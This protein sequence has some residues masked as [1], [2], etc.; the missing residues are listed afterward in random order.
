LLVR[1]AVVVAWDGRHPVW[2]RQALASID[3]QLPAAAQKCLVIDSADG[4]NLRARLA[5]DGWLITIGNWNDAAAARNAGLQSTDA[6]WLVF[7]D[8]DNIMAAGFLG[9]VC[10]AIAGADPQVGVGYSDIDYVD[11][12]LGN[13]QAWV[14]PEFDYWTLRADNYI[15]TGSAWRR[16]AVELSGGWPEGLGSYEDYALALELTRRGWRA[17]RRDGPPITM[18]VHPSSRTQE[19]IRSGQRQQDLWS[20]RSLGIVS[21][22]AGRSSTYERWER[23]LHEAEIPRHTGLYLVDNSA[24]P[25]F[26]RRVQ[27]SAQELAAA[28]NLDHVSV[29][30][31]T[32]RYDPVKEDGYFYRPRHL[33]IAQL[34]AQVLPTVTEDLVLTLEDDVEPP[35]DAIRRLTQQL[36]CSSSKNG[37]VV[38]GAYDMGDDALCAGRAD[39]GWGS[40]IPWNEVGSDPIDVGSVGGGCTI[41]ANWALA[42]RPITFRW[43][44]GLGWDGSICSDLR[45]RGYGIQVHGGVRC[46]HHVHGVLRH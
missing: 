27:Q 33:H 40:R 38:A 6:P 44:E 13:R 15:D 31:R 18:R 1:V 8:A 23:F 41:W 37:A 19:R 12:H 22:L 4:E 46:V 45:D 3:A 43:Q 30:F 28:R 20:V 42:G 26:G 39:G 10:A 34:Y 24:D 11:E 21:L 32:T 5:A 2:M 9:A 25:E 17:Q 29:L 35:P 7:W 14:V 16:M 36:G